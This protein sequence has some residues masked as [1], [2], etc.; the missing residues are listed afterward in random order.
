MKPEEITGSVVGV[1]LFLV[2]VVG[3][4]VAVAVGLVYHV[5]SRKT[6]Q[7]TTPEVSMK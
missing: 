3:L 1:I 5:R 6:K 7:S 4:L 2:V